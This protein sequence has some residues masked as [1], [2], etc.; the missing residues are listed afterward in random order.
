MSFL[1]PINNKR[2]ECEADKMNGYRDMRATDR[3]RLLEV[4]D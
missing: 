2:T 1:G 3:Q 4:V